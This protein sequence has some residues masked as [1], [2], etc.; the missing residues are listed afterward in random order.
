MYLFIYIKYIKYKGINT[1]LRH[2]HTEHTYSIHKLMWVASSPIIHVSCTSPFHSAASYALGSCNNNN[3]NNNSI[4]LC[5]C[6]ISTVSCVLVNYIQSICNYNYTIQHYAPFG[7]PGL[8]HHAL[9]CKC[10]SSCLHQC[11]GRSWQWTGT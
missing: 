11:Q 6:Y 7:S 9:T 8:G 1:I 10:L 5:I 2:M 3:N 4:I